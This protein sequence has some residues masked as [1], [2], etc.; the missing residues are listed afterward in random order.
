M[1][2]EKGGQRCYAPHYVHGAVGNVGGAHVDWCE[3]LSYY[4]NKMIKIRIKYNYTIVQNDASSAKN[5]ASS[6]K[7]K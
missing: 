5:D 1:L 7:K 2:K 4:R 6:A 3:L